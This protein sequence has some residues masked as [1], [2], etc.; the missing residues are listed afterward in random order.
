VLKH[1]GQRVRRGA[2]P[3]RAPSREHLE[4]HGAQREE[5]GAS[6][7]G[8]APHLLRRHVPH[9]AQQHAGRGVCGQR[10]HP[11]RR[12]RCDRPRQAEVQQLD[13]AVA[14]HE[15]VVGLEV[16]MND[17]TRVG[18]GEAARDLGPIRGRLGHGQRALVQARAQGG[19]F[20]ELRHDVGESVLLTHVV[21]REHV[22]IRE[23]AGGA[24]LL[25]EA[26]QSLGVAGQRAREDLDRDV[27]IQARVPRA[28]H[29]AHP[30]RAQR[31]QDLVRPEARAGDQR[32]RG[33]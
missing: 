21:H 26:P 33:R 31:A 8:L 30:P 12:F 25:L 5:V 20:E 1:G 22:R 3:E 14:R 7:R 4:E 9:R 29:L 28:V 15:D 19:S 27:A 18:G 11:G 32:R 10:L 17:A 2:A 16:A 24:R 6:I 23:A 13:V